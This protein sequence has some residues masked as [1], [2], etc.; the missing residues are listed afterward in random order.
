MTKATVYDFY[1]R[2]MPPVPRGS[3]HAE[4]GRWRDLILLWQKILVDKGIWPHPVFGVD[5]EDD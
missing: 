5:H 3:P 1:P 4:W 2:L